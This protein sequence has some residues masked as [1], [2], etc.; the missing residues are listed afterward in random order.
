MKMKITNNIK[1]KLK[2][3]FIQVWL[4]LSTLAP[5]KYYSLIITY[6]N[7]IIKLNTKI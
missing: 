7:F 4:R 5:T 2:H 3:Q 1:C 6:T